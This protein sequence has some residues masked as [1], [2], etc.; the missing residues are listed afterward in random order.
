MGTASRPP[1]AHARPRYRRAIVAAL[2]AVGVSACIAPQSGMRPGASAARFT[3][4]NNLLGNAHFDGGGYLPW[5]VSFTSPGEARGQVEG[6]AFCMQVDHAGT[7]RWDAQM[8]HRDMV[9][10]RGRSY[11]VQFK[12]WASA[13]M[14]VRPKV[15]MAGPPYAE[16]W[17]DTVE[18]T[19]EP[20]TF[21]AEFLMKGGDDPT[22]ELAFHAGGEL[23]PPTPY[24]VC[25][26][27]V[28]LLDPDFRRAST[29]A[30]LPRPPI[31][32]NQL[33][34]L[35]KLAKHAA[36]VSDVREP[37][38]FVLLDDTGAEVHSGTTRVHGADEASGDHVHVIDFSALQTRGRYRIRV[39]EA[40]SHPFAIDPGLYAGLRGDA[41]AYFYH[42]RSGIPIEM[43]HAGHARWTRPA[44][45]M[46]D[47]SIPCSSAANCSYTLDV[48]KGWYDAGDHGKYV[49]NGGIAVWTLLNLYER[50]E[51]LEGDGA[52]FADG[53]LSIPEGGNGVPDLL[54]EVR[55]QL[56][57][58][59]GMQVPEGDPRA[60]MAHHKMHDIKWSELPLR[61]DQ[62][63]LRRELQPPSTAATLNLAAVAAQA[64]RIYE[65]FDAAFA[66]RCR[67]A[68]ER[69]WLAAAK[70]P[71]VYAPK[72]GVGGGPYDDEDVSDERYWAAAELYVTTGGA[73]YLK[74]LRSSPHHR[75]VASV[76]RETSAEAGMGS[77]MT[78][79][80]TDA[81]GAISLAIVPSKLPAAERKAAR[82]GVVAAA[83]AYLE[84]LASQG[85]RVPLSPGR[86]GE[87]PWGS[88]SFVLNNLLVMALAHDFSGE[89]RYLEGV[90]TGMGYLLGRNPLDQS[91]VTGYGARP[92]RN[93][94]HRFWAQS[95]DRDYPPPPPGAVS[96]GPNSGLQDPH[97]QAAGL[98]GCAPQKCFVDHIEAWSVN[99][100]TINW[101][102]P[103]AWVAAFLDEKSSR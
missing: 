28:Y 4:S 86:S 103:L 71:A 85:Y 102:A 7:N 73:R 2:L 61:P 81:L 39:G 6:G 78:W 65:A 41:L 16:Y 40:L 36:L 93:P 72:K 38:P 3:E 12:A 80:V 47:R 91:Y 63:D 21:S 68:A 9:I 42:N 13:P 76:L 51:H 79:Q 101:N 56:E 66:A 75:A 33:G 8:R 14:R 44:G 53:A 34:Y 88:N 69:A 43:P 24:S 60:G 27:D 89:A 5:S 49:V 22:A 90:H 30:D 18:L 46:G 55:W 45:H 11:T 74:A 62:A 26:D 84:T 35:P 59:L 15:G 32:V 100:I 70:H 17:A 87:L 31:R 20:Q 57:F 50:S 10:Q 19:T 37:Q 29:A 97:A 48:S 98:A 94:H 77:S 52:P 92:L 83:D 82:Q 95:L 96:G 23:A 99:E 64:A 67:K 58:M 54:D 25:L 1:F